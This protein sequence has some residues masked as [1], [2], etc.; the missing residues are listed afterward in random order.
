MK[1]V[2]CVWKFTVYL[3]KVLEVMFT[4]IY[5]K[6]FNFS[7][8]ALC[9]V[10]SPISFSC[11]NLCNDFDGLRSIQSEMSINFLSLSL[12]GLPLC[13]A[14]NTEPVSWNFSVSLRTALQWGTSVYG[15]FSANCSCTKS[16]NLLPFWKT[17]STRRT[18][19]STERTIVCK[20]WIKLQ[21]LFNNWIQW[22]N[23]TLQRQFRYWQPHLR[24]RA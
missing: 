23:S 5:G 8:T 3:Q 24:T 12:D 21:P 6:G 17:Y 7:Q 19:S 4:S 20:N 15:N 1:H 13:S 16:V 22:N 11:A 10:A 2:Q 18:H 14:P 9:P